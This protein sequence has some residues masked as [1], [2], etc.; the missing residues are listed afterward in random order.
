MKKG[1]QLEKQADR[2]HDRHIVVGK[3]VYPT[4]A[5]VRGYIACRR[6]VKSLVNKCQTDEELGREIRKVFEK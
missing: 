4:V 1:R 3:L 5:Y 2:W 6:D